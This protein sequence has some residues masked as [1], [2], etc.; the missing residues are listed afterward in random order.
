MTP[1]QKSYLELRSYPSQTGRHTTM[2]K[3]NSEPRAQLWQEEYELLSQLAAAVPDGGTI[4]EIGTAEGGTAL[5][6][7]RAVRGRTVKVYT[8][9][10]A[11]APEAYDHLKNTEVTIVAQPSEEYA[12][13]WRKSASRPIDLLFIDGNHD[14]EHF[15]GDWNSWAPMVKRGGIVAAHDFDP[16]G[17]GGLVHLAVRIGAETVLARRLLKDPRHDYKLLYG[18]LDDPKQT[19]LSVEACHATLERLAQRIVAVRDLHDPA[20]CVVAD[21]GLALLLEACLRPSER[22]EF[23]SPEVATDP[24]RKYIVGA[25]PDGSFVG[26][27]RGRGIPESNLT[28]LDSLT[29]C[30]LVAGALRTNYA[31]LRQHTGSFHEFLFWSEAISML[32]HGFGMS[33]FP[34]NVPHLI[35]VP[36]IRALSRYTAREQVR[37]IMLARVLRTFVDWTP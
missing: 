8:V 6:M 10:V 18:T 11:P 2:M 31:Y 9:N 21:S 20:A 37:L 27:L 34:D 17:R 4:V 5:L 23:I 7:D 24:A 14:L 15:I 30:Y 25:Q 28:V 3:E 32:D 19:L 16:P 36:D 13:E 29:L 22:I 35:D 1:K 26:I 12:R 33:S